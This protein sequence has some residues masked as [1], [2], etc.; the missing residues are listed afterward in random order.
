M[1][2]ETEERNINELEQKIGELELQVAEV[3][4]PLLKQGIESTLLMLKDQLR[5]SLNQRSA[6]SKVLDE[7]IEIN[8]MKHSK[9]ED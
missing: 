6:N 2:D 7:D 1:E 3:K 5:S 9:G 8:D 4:T